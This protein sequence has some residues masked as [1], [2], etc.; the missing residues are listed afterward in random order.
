MSDMSF[1]NLINKVS[2]GLSK[3]NAEA[4]K[5]ASGKPSSVEE[6]E[7][8]F[9]EVKEHEL[10]DQPDPEAKATP[11][12][13]D[14]EPLVADI[15]PA[16]KKQKGGLTTRHKIW[17]AVA[18]VVLAVVAK[19]TLDQGRSGPGDQLADQQ[20]SQS[21]NEDSPLAGL[22]DMSFGEL[23]EYSPVEG[24]GEITFDDP[25]ANSDSVN[26]DIQLTF[27]VA[28]EDSLEPAQEMLDPFRMEIADQAPV[29]EP[30]DMP[31]LDVN[32]PRDALNDNPFSPS[33]VSN[34]PELGGSNSEK[35]DSGRSELNDLAGP[36]SDANVVALQTDA[37]DK[38]NR[39]SELQQ[40]L[41]NTRAELKAAEKRV[42]TLAQQRAGQTATQQSSVAARPSPRPRPQSNPVSVPPRP[43]MCI[44]AIA[45]A[46]RNCSTCVAHA[47][48][49]RNDQESMIGHGD[50]IEGMRVNIVGDRL[51]LQN[52][53]G[54][55]VHK[56][57]SS[58]NGCIG[59]ANT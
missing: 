58:P 9:E 19:N 34:S 55:S 5:R 33:T 10:A 44:T 17:A 28:P 54:Q 14:G 26:G 39:I 52:A 23:T 38:D 7:L 13:L 32:G 35:L 6:E 21:N 30:V 4:E 37:S 59:K 24:I 18:M 41:E 27:D 11:S 25:P 53:Q 31:V 12:D 51:D 46:A 49:V 43:Q 3:M 15:Q 57:W 29:P 8:L 1:K 50:Y 36:G 40:E 22:D 45:R 56:F 47:F 16:S 42:E 20:L 48:I 2:S